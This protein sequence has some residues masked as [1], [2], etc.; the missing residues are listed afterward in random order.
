ML[1]HPAFGH[2]DTL[3][4]RCKRIYKQWVSGEHTLRI[5]HLGELEGITVGEISVGS[6]DS[7]DQT[8]GST[9]VRQNHLTD[10]ISDLCGGM[11]V[12]FDVCVCGGVY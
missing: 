5:H 8:I 2:L 12:S 1:A 10:L 4:Q 9:D 7:E 3:Q 6:G 11:V